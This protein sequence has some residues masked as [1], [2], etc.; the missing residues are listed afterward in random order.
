VQ[1]LLLAVLIGVAQF[2][3]R[4]GTETGIGKAG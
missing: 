1:T 2:A 3:S 4:G